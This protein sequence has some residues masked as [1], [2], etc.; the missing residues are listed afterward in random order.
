MTV[1][2]V[3]HAN[4]EVGDF[5]NPGLGH[6]DQPISRSGRRQ[7]R[8]LRNYLQTR[9]I[10]RIYVSEYVRTRQT[11]AAFARRAGIAPTT[12][13]RLNEIDLGRI[14]GMSDDEIESDYPDV[15]NAYHQRTADFRFPGGETGTEATTR[16]A[17]FLTDQRGRSGDTVAVAHDGIVRVLLCHLLNIPVYRRFAFRFGTTN[18]L[19][20]ALDQQRDEWTVVRFNQHL[21]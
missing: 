9:R 17:A 10:E 12:D 11:I 5:F 20:V 8:R 1:Y 21:P 13:A 14:E 19:E 7:A 2:F 3:R 15:W 4:E 18:L 6:Q 16:I